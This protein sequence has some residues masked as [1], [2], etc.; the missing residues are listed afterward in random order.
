MCVCAHTCM[1][2]HART[3]QVTSVM[4]DSVQPF[5]LYPARLLCPWSSPSK[6]TGVSCHAFLQGIFLTQELNPTSLMS[7]ALA[8]RFFKTSPPGKSLFYIE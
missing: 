6:N 2:V 1:H 3:C 8:G 5:V 4:S 7:P